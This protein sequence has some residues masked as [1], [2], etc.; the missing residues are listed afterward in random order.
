MGHNYF[1]KIL[2]YTALMQSGRQSLGTKEG[3][4]SLIYGLNSSTE[5]FKEISVL[6]NIDVITQSE[7]LFVK[8]E[9]S[10]ATSPDVLSSLKNAENDLLDSLKSL[11]VLKQADKYRKYAANTHSSANS[12]TVQGL[13][14]D[15]FHTACASHITRLNNSLKN[16]TMIP[17]DRELIRQRKRNMIVI[18]EIYKEMQREALK[19]R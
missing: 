1:N 8:Q 10:V 4:S 7:L 15:V 17:E 13:P 19:K 2:E 5:L 3:Y 16:T 14:K 6:K 12:K 11:E 18:R 9:L